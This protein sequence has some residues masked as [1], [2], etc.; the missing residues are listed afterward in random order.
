MKK[1][2]G[3][4]GL[5]N[6]TPNGKG[7]PEPK[8][9][10][11]S[12]GA[13]PVVTRFFANMRIRNRQ[14]SIDKIGNRIE[15]LVTKERHKVEQVIKAAEKTDIHKV[16][17]DARALRDRLEEAA[18]AKVKFRGGDGDEGVDDFDAG[19][20]PEE[21][22]KAKHECVEAANAAAGVAW[23]SGT[24]HGGDPKF[25]IWNAAKNRCADEKGI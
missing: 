14:K 23:K 3:T 7:K 11:R 24:G 15:D 12:V 25:V 16:I 20:S 22:A 5:S 8:A 19:L 6:P 4:K 17:M 2:W 21:I 10:V 18:C 1:T 13:I 9:S